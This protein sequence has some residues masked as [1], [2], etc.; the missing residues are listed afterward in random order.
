MKTGSSSVTLNHTWLPRTNTESSIV[1]LTSVFLSLLQKPTEYQGIPFVSFL[2]CCLS[3]LRH[4]FQRRIFQNCSYKYYNGFYQRVARQRP[5]RHEY[6]Q[7]TLGDCE[8]RN[9]L[10]AACRKVSRRAAVVLRNA[11]VFRKIRTKETMDRRISR[12]QPAE[13]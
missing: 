11:N 2:R 10:A 9:K 8:S 13:R 6:R 7:L 3:I 1:L 5:C 4:F 12:Q